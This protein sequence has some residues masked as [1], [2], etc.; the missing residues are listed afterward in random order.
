MFET[1]RHVRPLR[2]VASPFA[3]FNLLF[4]SNDTPADRFRYCVQT[5]LF[6]DLRDHASCAEEGLTDTPEHRQF[7]RILVK[8]YKKVFLQMSRDLKGENIF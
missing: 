2:R 4:Q 1:L 3:R 7:Q 8:C 5:R 6:L